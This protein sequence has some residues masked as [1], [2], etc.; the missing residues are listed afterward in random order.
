MHGLVHNLRD[1]GTALVVASRSSEN[2]DLVA[3]RKMREEHHA[4]RTVAHKQC[5]SSSN[6]TKFSHV[7]GKSVS[8]A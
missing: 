4:V 3:E 1:Q 7:H 6:V 8:I 5:L 2:F